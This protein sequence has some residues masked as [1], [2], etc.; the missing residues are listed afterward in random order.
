MVRRLLNTYYRAVEYAV[1]EWPAPDLQS[2]LPFISIIYREKCARLFTF[3]C[4]SPEHEDSR[5]GGYYKDRLTDS[6]EHIPAWGSSTAQWICCFSWNSKF[7]HR[8]NGVKFT[9]M[10]IRPQNQ[11][12]CWARFTKSFTSRMGTAVAQCLRCCA[13]NLKVAGSIPAGVIGIF[14]WHKILPIALWPWGR[15]SL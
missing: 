12:L 14:H 6:M 9:M 4:H 3:T 15:L 13:T 5:R 11:N 8:M 10:F 1:G 7:Y 2:L